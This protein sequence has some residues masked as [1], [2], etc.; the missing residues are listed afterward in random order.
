MVFSLWFPNWKGSKLWQKCNYLSPFLYRYLWDWKM[1]LAERP[2]FCTRWTW[3][4]MWWGGPQW[5]WRWDADA[6]P[7]PGLRLLIASEESP[8]FQ[9]RNP[10][11]R[12]SWWAKII[13]C[14][15]LGE[16]INKLVIRCIRPFLWQDWPEQLV[17]QSRFQWSAKSFENSQE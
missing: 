13:T 12:W 8:C 1:G 3:V 5:S 16:Q 10:V 7:L 6:W 15:C 17:R 4:R 9:R 11:L 14:I 2:W